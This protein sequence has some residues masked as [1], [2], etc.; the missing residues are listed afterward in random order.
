[1]HL[2]LCKRFS[3]LNFSCP[4]SVEEFGSNGSIVT[5]RNEIVSP[6]TESLSHSPSTEDVMSGTANESNIEDV[7]PRSC[8]T[9]TRKDSGKD[10]ESIISSGMSSICN[11]P[12]MNN[13]RSSRYSERYDASTLKM[14]NSYLEEKTDSESIRSIAPKRKSRCASVN[15]TNVSRDFR[16][17]VTKFV[18]FFH[19]ST[20]LL[21]PCL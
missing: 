6:T 2:Y 16:K 19:F 5:L 21:F 15:L 8:N 3:N 11:S 14:T 13:N 7:N 12:P 9:L 18:Y 1:M 4:S 20:G 17:S 10:T